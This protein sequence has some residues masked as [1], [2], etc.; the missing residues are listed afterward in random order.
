M[1]CLPYKNAKLS[2]I[3]QKFGVNPNAIQPNGHTGL[4]WC[5]YNAWGMDLVSP[6][7]GK[8]C[9]I[10]NAQTISDDITELKRG[11][12]IMVKD[13]NS[14]MYYVY[15]HCQPVF[16]VN[17][18]QSVKQG[19]DVVAQMGNSGDVYSQGVFVPLED[20]DKPP[21]KG[22][23]LHQEVFALNEDGT[24]NYINPLNQIDFSIPVQPNIFEAIKN[25]I[26]NMAKLFKGR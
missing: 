15:W 10:I 16:P 19:K 24:R 3:T 14:D 8:I 17:L 11:Y 12:G 26:I 2:D 6:C 23:H 9:S 18:W 7:D 20:R 4:D 13:D 22:T 21:F 25:I 1:I 5:P